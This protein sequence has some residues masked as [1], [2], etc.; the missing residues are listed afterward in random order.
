V[1]LRSWAVWAASVFG[2]VLLLGASARHPF[3]PHPYLHPQ[4]LVDIGRRRLNLYCTGKGS[5]TV[6][7]D[8]A[9]DDP[10]IAWRFVQPAVAKYTRVCSYD[11][12]GL[13]FSDPAPGPRDANAYVN[14]LHSLLTRGH[15]SGPYV[16]VGF[17]ISGLFARLYADRFPKD[18][19]GMV[20][21]DPY[22]VHRD[23][24]LA[25]LAPA[26]APIADEH[27]FVAFLQMCHTAALHAQLRSGTAA[28]R[29]CMWPTGPGD[30]QLP[31]AVRSSLVQQWQRPGAWED[32]I[33]AAQ[34]DDSTEVTRAQ[35]N[36]G[37][38]PLIVLTSDVRV[39]LA[40]L[41]LT[42]RQLDRI[43]DAYRSWHREIAA[44]SSRGVDFVLKGC[45][46]SPPVEQPA[47]V[48]SA[49][50]EVSQQVRFS[51]LGRFDSGKDS[52]RPV[53][54]WREYRAVLRRVRLPSAELD[55]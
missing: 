48:I 32:L 19:A 3:D 17:S 53:Y 49:I 2:A 23:Q 36:Y 39:D 27:S 28:F 47:S 6:I 35:R 18:V 8:T 42:R 41:P 16:I 29:N 10:T 25:A 46:D 50:D 5:P 22:V 38:M 21:V 24:R 52:A 55:R 30:P 12:A 1:S 31:V 13:G 37:D 51:R 40:G 43:A 9:G 45:G 20:L 54:V 26:L 7:L 33:L 15:V 34:A 11:A 4:L 44:L 14:D